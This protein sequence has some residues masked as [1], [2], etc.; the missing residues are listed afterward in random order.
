[1]NRPQKRILAVLGVLAVF[2]W[3][4]A[5]TPVRST[6][7]AGSVPRPMAVAVQTVSS[8]PLTEVPDRW[9]DSPFLMDRGPKGTAAPETVSGKDSY[10]LN[11]IL[12]DP[13]TPSAILNN[14]VVCVGE[15]LGEWEVSEIQKDRVILSNGSERRVLT[16]S[17]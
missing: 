17:D 10:V 16:S 9:G 6:R 12:W 14:R 7:S 13:R 3:I 15:R 11:G 8:P 1:M 4:R 5:L 2:V